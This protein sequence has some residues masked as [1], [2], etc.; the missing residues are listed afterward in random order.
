[1]KST[2]LRALIGFTTLSSA[3]TL[4]CFVALWAL[5]G[6]GGG[7]WWASLLVVLIGL[8]SVI[9]IYGSTLHGPV[10]IWIDEPK[11]A[12]RREDRKSVV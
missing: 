7:V 4:G 9:S 11:E 3:I 12:E 8:V 6:Y 2:F 5:D 10:K 1:M